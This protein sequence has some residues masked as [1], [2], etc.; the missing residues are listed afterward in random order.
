MALV[1]C[2]LQSRL[3]AFS[4]TLTTVALAWYGLPMPRQPNPTTIAHQLAAMRRRVDRRCVVCGRQMAGVTTRRQTCGEA[5]R[6]RLYRERRAERRAA[7]K[8]VTTR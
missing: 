3:S 4:I 1:R 8:G 2:E 7:A 6:S 5:C